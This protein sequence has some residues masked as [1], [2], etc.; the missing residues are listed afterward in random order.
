MEQLV[1]LEA[2]RAGIEICARNLCSQIQERSCRKQSLAHHRHRHHRARTSD[3]RCRGRCNTLEEDLEGVM[4]EEARAVE[5]VGEV[6]EGVE[7]VVVEKV[8]VETVGVTVGG[9]EVGVTAGE[10]LVGV[11]EAAMVA[12][13]VV[14][15]MVMA[16]RVEVM[17]DLR[18]FHQHNSEHSALPLMLYRS[19][20]EYWHPARRQTGSDSGVRR[21]HDRTPPRPR[22]I[23]CRARIRSAPQQVARREYTVVLRDPCKQCVHD[24]TSYV[25]GSQSYSRRANKSVRGVHQQSSPGRLEGDTS[26]QGRLLAC[27]D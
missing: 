6:T 16:D 27:R 13:A 5:T 14:V 17:E 22:H 25:E 19:S 8:V 15:A 21:Y 7:K 20:C 3:S 4:V 11:M 10:A 2:A 12:A 24:P 23:Q 26:I 18:R 9:L 1:A